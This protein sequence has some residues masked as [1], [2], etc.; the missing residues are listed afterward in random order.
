MKK[1]LLLLLCWVLINLPS[2]AQFDTTFIKSNI[3]R[4]ADSLTTAF[5]KKDWKKFARF[6]YPALVGTLGGTDEFIYY[7]ANMFASIPDT[8]W[9]KYD[10]GNVLQVVKTA[11]DYQAIFELYSIVEFEGTRII[12]TNYMLAESIDGGMSW[13]FFDTQGDRAATKTIKPDLSDALIIPGRKEHREL[14]K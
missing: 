12:S 4:C 5:K 6:S 2:E 14:I 7:V 13:T 10:V 9:K 1:V 8:A 3:S 11:G